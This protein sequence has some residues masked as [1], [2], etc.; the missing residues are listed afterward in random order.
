MIAAKGDSGAPIVG[1]SRGGWRLLAVLSGYTA[2]YPSQDL[3]E[4]SGKSVITASSPTGGTVLER[5]IKT[6][7]NGVP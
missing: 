4:I 1:W 6:Y 3:G 5:W 2:D 7:G